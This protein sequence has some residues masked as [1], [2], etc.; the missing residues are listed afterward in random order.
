[1]VFEIEIAADPARVLDGLL[2]TAAYGEWMDMHARWPDGPPALELGARFRQNVRMVGRSAEVTWTVEDV[3]RDRLVL[4]GEGPGGLSIENTYTVES[5]GATTLL[6]CE[7][8]FDGGP[9]PLGGRLG[10]VVL[11]KVREASE[12]S[13]A[14]FAAWLE[15]GDRVAIRRRPSRL[16]WRRWASNARLVAAVEENTRALEALREEIARSDGGGSPPGW[17]TA[18]LDLLRR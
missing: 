1:M 3:D 5:A 6:H 10:T 7:S 11:A 18:P 9:L 2:D 15:R 8:A 13:M 4:S 12:T 14:N 17:L 16:P